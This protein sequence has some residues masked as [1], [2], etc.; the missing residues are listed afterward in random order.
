MRR[1]SV[2][3]S[4]RTSVTASSSSA[5]DTACEHSLGLDDPRDGDDLVP[6]HDERPR[7]AFRA[8]NLG[9]DEHVLDLLPPSGEPVACAPTAYLK[10]WLGGANQPR[11]PA[12]LALERDGRALE[13]HVVV[14]AD[15]GEAA[16]EVETHR[17]RRRGEQL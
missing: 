11:P 15:S 10:P 14:L 5:C 16:A 12:N 1:R 17:P 2:S 6:A 8:G 3:S 9:V 7:L 13:P 4:I